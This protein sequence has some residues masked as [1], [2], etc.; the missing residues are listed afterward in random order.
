MLQSTLNQQ[1]LRQ[2]KE[3]ELN[4]TKS[5]KNQTH[6]LHQADQKS[7][8]DKTAVK[9]SIV[10]ANSEG[11]KVLSLEGN[12]TIHLNRTSPAKESDQKKATTGA[13]TATSNST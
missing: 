13:K 8:S 5:V 7:I 3:K 6:H 1:I 10:K 9:D 11:S 4:L 12:T 2:K